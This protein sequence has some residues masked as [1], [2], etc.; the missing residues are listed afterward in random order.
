MKEIEYSL[1]RTKDNR[2]FLELKVPRLSTWK[3]N[4]ARLRFHKDAYRHWEI[5]D[6]FKRF[7][8]SK[9]YKPIMALINSFRITSKN[10][11]WKKSYFTNE[12]TISFVHELDNEK[13]SF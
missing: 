8:E 6:A 9:Q 11:G 5:N 7:E 10:V 3:R 13:I 4:L 1:T 12:E 2:I